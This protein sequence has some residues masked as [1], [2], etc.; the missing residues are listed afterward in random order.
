MAH[1]LGAFLQELHQLPARDLIPVDLPISDTREEWLNV[2][3]RI[4][5]KLFPLMRPDAH[6]QVRALFETYLD[7]PSI[8]RFTPVLRHGDFGGGNIIFDPEMQSIAGVIDFGFTSLGDPAVDAVGLQ[9]FGEDFFKAS[10]EAYPELTTYVKRTEFYRG[11]AFALLDALFGI[12]HGDDE[13]LEDGLSS[14]V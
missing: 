14:Y 6:E 11:S 1:Q 2:Y 9:F 10:C 4:Q 12:E 3:T 13:A 5:E 7:T 8:H